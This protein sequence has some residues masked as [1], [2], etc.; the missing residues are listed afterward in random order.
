VTIRW[1]AFAASAFLVRRVALR[2][3]LGGCGVAKLRHGADS[4]AV[5]TLAGAGAPPARPEWMPGP[6]AV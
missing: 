6:F 2:G 3:L 4:L 1:D 5:R